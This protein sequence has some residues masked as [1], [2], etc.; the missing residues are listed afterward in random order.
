MKELG[1]DHQ[2][3]YICKKLL[4]ELVIVENK[5]GIDPRFALDLHLFT[6][7]LIYRSENVFLFFLVLFQ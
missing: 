6:G 7:D 3:L 2:K 5:N 4:Y 1:M